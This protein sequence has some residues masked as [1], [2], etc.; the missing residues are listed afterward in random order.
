MIVGWIIEHKI[1]LTVTQKR[2]SILGNYRAPHNGKGHRISING[3]LN[4]YA[5]L[6]TFVHEMAHLTT[7]VKHQK[8]VSSH[9]SEWK[10]QF[11]LLMDEFFGRKILPH[12][13]RAAL[14]IYLINPASTHCNDPHLIKVLNKYNKKPA[15]HVQDLDSNALFLWNDGK[16][17]KKGEKLRKRYKCYEIKTNRIYL[18]SSIAEVKRL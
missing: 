15:L 9:G 2:N 13:V 7:C 3:D 10:E 14:K 11:K 16:I 12:D 17:F 6:V 8:R 1:V 18:F 4:P 5:F